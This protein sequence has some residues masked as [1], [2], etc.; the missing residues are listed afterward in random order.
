MLDGLDKASIYAR[1]ISKKKLN[2]EAESDNMNE[3]IVVTY[4][5]LGNAKGNRLPINDLL[6][7]VFNDDESALF[8]I[9]EAIIDILYSELETEIISKTSKIQ[10]ED[11]IN[12]IIDKKFIA[13]GLTPF[14]RNRFNSFIESPAWNHYLSTE[15]GF[16]YFKL[17]TLEH[18]LNKSERGENIIYV[19]YD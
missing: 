6:F 13:W 4:S 12:T 2:F 16:I 15:D 19:P 17:N 3:K 14:N 18:Y 10:S 9:K 5:V 11:Y 8:A 1:R 7:G